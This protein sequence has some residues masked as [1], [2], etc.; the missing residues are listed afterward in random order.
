M[1][2]IEYVNIWMSEFAAPRGPNVVAGW[3]KQHMEW[4]ISW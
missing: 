1:Y 2:C 4:A 3:G